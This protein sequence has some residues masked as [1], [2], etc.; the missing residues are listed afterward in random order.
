MARRAAGDSVRQRPGIH[1]FSDPELGIPV[2]RQAGINSAEQP[3][4]ERL[5][6]AVQQDGE[7]LEVVT[8]ILVR[9]SRGSRLCNKVH[10][11]LQP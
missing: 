8:A 9:R 11:L 3:A 7:I 6:R 2:V 1:R 5:C 10:V 4:A